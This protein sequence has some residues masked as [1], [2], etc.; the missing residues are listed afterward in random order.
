MKKNVLINFLIPMFFLMGFNLTVQGQ[1]IAFNE[2]FSYPA[3]NLLGR[4]TWTLQG[5]D[6]TNP[7][8]VVAPGLI[9]PGYMSSGIG[10]AARM[11]RNSTGQ[12]LFSTF[13]GANTINSGSVYIAALVKVE[14]A[15]IDGDYFL[16]FK[17]TTG[18]SLQVFKGRLYAKDAT[19]AGNL[20]FGVTKSSSASTVPVSWSPT[21][22]SFGVTYLV[23]LKYTFVAGAANDPVSVFVFNSAN[24][25]PI[26]EPVSPNATASD[27]GSDGI[28]QRCVQ[29]RQ[30]GLN[31]PVS[32]VDGIRVGQSWAAAV[33]PA[34]IPIP[35]LSEWG[36]IILG[37]VL[38]GAG[39][40]FILRRNS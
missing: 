9:Y 37:S 20:V 6:N 39:T 3:G 16:S 40:L 14:S 29:L 13:V 30:G 5:T 32:V 22:Y 2:N 35:T 23:V 11:A 24:P 31:S 27:A 18:A 10:L 36:L 26:A 15:T 19:G 25:F 12:D 17:E 21:Y 7:I 4:G 34:P 38:V 28:G 1:L 8:Q 33:T